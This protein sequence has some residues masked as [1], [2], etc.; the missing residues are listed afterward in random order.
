MSENDPAWSV[1]WARG[2]TRSSAPS[3][4]S[5]R[6]GK[7]VGGDPITTRANETVGYVIMEAGH[8]TLAGVEFE[9]RVGAA[10]ILGAV[11]GAPFTYAFASAFAQTP[12]V[13]VVTQAGMKGTDGSWAQTFGPTVATSTSLFLSVDEDDVGDAERNHLGEQVAYLVFRKARN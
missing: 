3:S 5:M 11:D 8:G 9:A 12:V 6:T 1:F 4:T 13:A 10:T 7:M 2:S